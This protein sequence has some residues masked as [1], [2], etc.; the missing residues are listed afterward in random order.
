MVLVTGANKG[1]GK[2]LC[3]ELV[4]E[5]GF[6][7]LLGSRDEARGKAAVRDIVDAA[8]DCK[9]RLELLPID[10]SDDASVAAAADIVTAKYGKDPAPLYGIINNAGLGFSR[11][12]PLTLGANYYGTKR[13]C[14]A[15]MPLLDAEVGRIVNTASA[16]GPMYVAGD[17]TP[18]ERAVLTDP[19][20]TPEQL[21]ELIEQTKTV[22]AYG[23]SKA[24]VNAYTRYLARMHPHLRINAITPGFIDTDMT[25]FMGATKPPEEGTKAAI[26]A[27][28]GDLE[29]NGWYYGSDAVRSPI[30]R[31]R[32]PGDPP[33]TGP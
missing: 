8:P 25:K 9:D 32:N 23:F 11:N 29:G 18:T 16:S 21:E 14:E 30:D 6:H 33:Y 31:Y 26:Y 19:S 28:T 7:V 24:C 22:N 5:Q 13:V 3:R 27:L 10:V 12:L 17:S 1:I 2:A 4:A 20:V 15:F